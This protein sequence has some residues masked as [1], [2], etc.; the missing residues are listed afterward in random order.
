MRFFFFSV[1][2]LNSMWL[3]LKKHRDVNKQNGSCHLYTGMCQL[4]ENNWA[5][6][7][8]LDPSWFHGTKTQSLPVWHWV[9]IRP[10]FCSMIL[11]LVTGS[12]K[13]N[14]SCHSTLELIWSACSHCPS[15]SSS[16]LATISQGT[17][18]TL[19]QVSCYFF[20]TQMATTFWKYIRDKKKCLVE[21]AGAWKMGSH[22]S[23]PPPL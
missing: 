6:W 17:S 10:D 16:Q 9:P 14:I 21:E 8:F 11:S 4:G 22:L 1:V 20:P 5:S 13:M 18:L 7:L 3:N 15:I 12:V 23:F 2:I 19:P